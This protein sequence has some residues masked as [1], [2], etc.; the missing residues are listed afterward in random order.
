[1]THH[2]TASLHFYFKSTKYS[3]SIPAE[4][5]VAYRLRLQRVKFRSTVTP[6]FDYARLHLASTMEMLFS[7]FA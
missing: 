1:M 6:S 4:T 2:N 7:E 3:Y 5:H